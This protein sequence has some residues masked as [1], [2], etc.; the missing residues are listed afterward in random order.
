MA[1]YRLI[2]STRNYTIQKVIHYIWGALKD[3]YLVPIPDHVDVVN[4]ENSRPMRPDPRS[5]QY[6]IFRQLSQCQ[7]SGLLGTYMYVR[8]VITFRYSIFPF[9]IAIYR[10]LTKIKHQVDISI[11]CIPWVDLAREMAGSLSTFPNDFCRWGQ[12][13]NSRDQHL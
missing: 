6:N 8:L 4:S 2:P 1:R 5:R 11:S 7:H 3:Q 12:S 10:L 9:K 13:T